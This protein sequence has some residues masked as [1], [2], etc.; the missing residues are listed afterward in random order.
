M[1]TVR[2]LCSVAL[3]AVF[4]HLVLGQ[5]GKS[6]NIAPIPAAIPAA[7]KV[8]ISNAGED[9]VG[10]D[11]YSGA[12]D[13]CYNDFYRQVRTMNR[14]EL[15]AAPSDADI[16]LE[17]TMTSSALPSDVMKGSTVPG[18]GYESIFR[19]RVLD[20]KSQV[21][22]WTF[23]ERVAPA[24]L[25]MNRN[26]NFDNALKQIVSDLSNLTPNGPRP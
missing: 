19:L 9:N 24:V 26:K 14:F 8:F 18:A 10:G 6:A 23:D 1:K 21:V 2:M 25:K 13:R 4:T 11:L 22:L 12:Q 17:I 7:Q 16:I 5:E 3:A 20:P 15:V